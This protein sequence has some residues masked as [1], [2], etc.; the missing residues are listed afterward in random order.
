MRSQSSQTQYSPPVTLCQP[1]SYSKLVLS[2]SPISRYTQSRPT[3][4]GASPKTNS[5]G[6]A[7]GDVKVVSVKI[8]RQFTPVS[9]GN[10]TIDDRFWSPRIRVNREQTLRHEY[11][12]CKKTGRILGFKPDWTPESREQARH[13][14]NDSDVAKWVEAVSYSLSS[15]PDP[16]LEALLDEVV[17]LFAGAQQPDGY[18]NTYFSFVE[19]DKRWTNLRDKHELY[20]A[21]HLFEAAV[22]HYEATGSQKLLD[23]ACRFADHIDSVF[24]PEPGK[25][26]GYPGHQEIELGLVRLYHATGNERYLNLSK[27]FI[28]ERGQQPHYYD[29]EARERG[30]DPKD[31][32][33]KTYEYC[34]AHLPVREQ[35]EVVGHAVRALYMYSAMADLAGEFGDETLLRACEK[36]WENLCLKR[37]Y[38]TGGVG[39]EK[40]NEGF[41]FDYDL[42]NETAYTETCA[43]IA[44]VFWNHRLLQLDCDGR[45]ADVME[46]ALYNGV[47]SGVS[48]DGTTFFYDNPLASLGKHKRSGWFTCA[49]C[50]PNIARLLASLGGYI[51]SES[52]TD[53]V[54]HLYIQGTGKLDVGGRTVTLKQ[55]TDYP[56]DGKI[57]IEVSPDEPASFG[58]KLRIPDW[59]KGAN[60][61]VNGESVNL[62][63]M[64]EKGYA[65]IERQWKQ[66]DRV[67]LELPMPIERMRAHPKVRQDAGCVALQRGPMVFCLEEVDNQAPVLQI[68][69]PGD[70]KLSAEKRDDLL[71]GVVTIKG[72]AVTPDELDWEGQLYRTEPTKMKPCAITAIPY[73]SWANRKIGRMAVWLREVRSGM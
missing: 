72:E 37:M 57:N 27:Y 23:V 61:T 28:D 56:W 62:A 22:A 2:R 71:E 39:P 20:S 41:T 3:N 12:E 43:A 64:I 11:E 47:L 7:Q 5:I 6:A 45:Y 17:D 73:Y 13:I 67:E 35:A 10:V 26:R 16:E 69:L 50:P 21:G 24:G 4:A 52:E 31:F 54:V 68:A 40:S 59:C 70:A 63:S 18:L 53:A 29:I 60:L 55:T 46:R 8:K 19:P 33:A 34:Q 1:Y 30:E 65:G 48:L 36:L 15:H 38:L 51:Y 44:L 14:F 66:G 32:W 9:F 25:K 58:L 49:C 42:P